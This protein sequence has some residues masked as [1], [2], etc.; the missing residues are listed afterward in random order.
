MA[1]HCT[2]EVEMKFVPVTVSVKDGPPAVVLA[3]ESELI[4][5]TG[6]LLG[7]GGEVP[8]PPPQLPTRRASSAVKAETT[9]V[10]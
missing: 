6:L 7:G 1:F 8:P 3:G 9:A 4:V 10:R 5:G 2:V